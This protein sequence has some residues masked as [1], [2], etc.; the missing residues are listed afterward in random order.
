MSSTSNKA[1]TART[2]A[3]LG[4]KIRRINAKTQGRLDQLMAKSNEGQ[5]SKAEQIELEAVAGDL[6]R[7]SI[8]NA[9]ILA[10]HARTPTTGP[11]GDSSVKRQRKAPAV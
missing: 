5:I 8:E 3:S 9:M 4:P 1:R 2:A 10:A 11:R 6:E 7:L